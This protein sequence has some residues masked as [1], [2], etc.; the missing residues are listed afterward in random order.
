MDETRKEVDNLHKE[1]GLDET[2][3]ESGSSESESEAE[4]ED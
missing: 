1:H 4:G 2:S 3:V